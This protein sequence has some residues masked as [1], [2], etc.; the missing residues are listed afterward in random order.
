MV[1]LWLFLEQRT[2]NPGDEVRMVALLTLLGAIF[3]GGTGVGSFS[4]PR[5]LRLDGGGAFFWDIVFS[6]GL[7]FDGSG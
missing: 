6:A 7:E 2:F 3:A 4:A 1:M 5:F